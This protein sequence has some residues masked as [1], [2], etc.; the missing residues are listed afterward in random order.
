V[1]FER[2]VRRKFGGKAGGSFLNRLKFRPPGAADC[3]KA[4]AHGERGPVSAVYWEMGGSLGANLGGLR[5]KRGKAA[6]DRWHMAR[7]E[8]EQR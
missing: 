2:C 5:K 1:N 6:S 4:C 3:D 8:A 7:E